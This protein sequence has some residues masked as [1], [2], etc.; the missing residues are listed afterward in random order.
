V[1]AEAKLALIMP[2][3]NNVNEVKVVK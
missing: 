1:R 2:N 3:A